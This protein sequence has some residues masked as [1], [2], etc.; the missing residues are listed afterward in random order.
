M[1]KWCRHVSECVYRGDY[2]RHD[3]RSMHRDE[4]LSRC[5]LTHT[6]LF[7]F[8]PHRAAR[9]LSALVKS[10]RM[11]ETRTRLHVVFR[12]GIGEE[13]SR[14]RAETRPELYQKKDGWRDNSSWW[15]SLS[16]EIKH[17]GMLPRLDIKVQAGPSER[18][19]TSTSTHFNAPPSKL[20]VFKTKPT[21]DE[22]KYFRLISWKKV[23][24][25]FFLSIQW[26]CSNA[27]TLLMCE[28]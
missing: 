9:V 11:S 12:G 8:S 20:V 6:H 19:S 24:E 4:T 2:G 14:S 23:L 18:T 26:Y 17:G 27:R 13:K 15:A 22:V 16:S 3:T 25:I 21:L 28:I 1:H 5:I 10:D 7:F